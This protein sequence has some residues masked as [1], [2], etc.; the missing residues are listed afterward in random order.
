MFKQYITF[1]FPQGSLVKNYGMTRMDPYVRLRV[2][3]TVYETH[4]DPSGGKTPRWNK[5]IQW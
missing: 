1:V 3:H 2:G 4:A 5:R